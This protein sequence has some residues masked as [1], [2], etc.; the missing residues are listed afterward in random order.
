MRVA[1]PSAVVQLV[2]VNSAEAAAAL[3][4]ALLYVPTEQAVRPRGQHFWHEIEGLRVET[5]DGRGLGIVTEVMRTGA[6][7]VYVVDGAGGELLIPAIADVVREID[8][9]AGRIV[10]R[11]LPGLLPG[12]D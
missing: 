12:D 4:G 10:V 11:L 6:N 9:R 1:G 3:R 7:D 5:E 2:G 8:V